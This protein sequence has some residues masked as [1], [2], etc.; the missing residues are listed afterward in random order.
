[1]IKYL[2]LLA[3]VFCASCSTLRF[4]GVYKLNIEQ[5]NIVTQEMVDQLEPGM[6]RGQVEYIMGS[7]LIHDT[8]NPNRW[9]Y[10]YSVGRGDEARGQYVFSI[11]FDGDR[12]SRYTGDIAPANLVEKTISKKDIERQLDE[13]DK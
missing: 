10:Y 3:L 4:P 7:A 6:S 8:F 9:D 1:M 13:V 2:S 11:F 12:L 5:G